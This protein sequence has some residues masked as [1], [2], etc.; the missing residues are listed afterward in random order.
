MSVLND[1]RNEI[2]INNSDA[3]CLLENWVEERVVQSLYPDD[4]VEKTGNKAQLFRSGNQGLLTNDLNAKAENLTVVRDTYRPPTKPPVRQRGQKEELMELMFLEQVVNE[5]KSNAVDPERE[6]E[7]YKSITMKDFNKDDFVSVP[8]A[9]TA[10]HDYKTEQPI[11]FWSEHRDKV[12]GVSQTKTDSAF[13][14]ND[15]FSKPIDEYW[16][17]PAPYE[18]EEYPK[19]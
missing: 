9:P 4:E 16:N 1:G 7:E 19:M 8:P 3:K 2:R 18:Q 12:T 17:E 13:R 5:M 14:K 6:V 11:T 15:A 10:C